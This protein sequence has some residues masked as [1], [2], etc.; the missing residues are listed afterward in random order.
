MKVIF[1]EYLIKAA[2]LF[3]PW[4]FVLVAKGVAAGYFIFH[5]KARSISCNFYAALFPN[6]NRVYHY[7]ATWKQFLN[8]IYIYLDRFIQREIRELDFT[9]EGRE[10]VVAAK[11]GRK[12]CILL[13]SHM[14]N[15]ELAAHLLTKVHTNVET[16]LFMGVRDKEEIEKVQKESVRQDGIRVIGVKKN[17]DSPVDIVEGLQFLRK[18]GFVSM[19]GDVVWRTDQRTVTG[20]FIGRNV[21]IP[22]APFALALVSEAPL[23]VFFAFRTP[24]GQ[25]RFSVLPPIHVRSVEGADRSLS[26]QKAA[27]SYLHSLEG[28]LRNHPFEWF[29]FDAF[30]EY[31]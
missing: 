25:Y 6:R 27:Q 11:S 1:Y 16:L 13:A 24:T 31:D 9:I 12:G 4:L 30:L 3:G 29:H 28:A 14:G 7:Y 2:K 20:S 26:I 8:F 23:L 10:H 17:E 21:R 5:A 19:A 18:G 15:W 22:E